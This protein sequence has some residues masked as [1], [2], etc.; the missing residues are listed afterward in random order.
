[1]KQTFESDFNEFYRLYHEYV[2]K[3]SKRVCNDIESAEDI[4]QEVF[5]FL[6][7]RPELFYSIEYPKSFLLKLTR[8]KTIDV[9]RRKRPIL[10]DFRLHRIPRKNLMFVND[11]SIDWDNDFLTD[12]EVISKKDTDFDY[13]EIRKFFIREL[14]SIPARDRDIFVCHRGDEMTQ[15]EI[16]KKFNLTERQIRRIL[17]A[18]TKKLRENYNLYFS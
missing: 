14:N 2:F 7:Q 17:D 18:V 5:I 3:V 9:Y 10:I 1:M 13:L 4:S 15:Q 12:Y 6:Y 8:N 11:E 16:G